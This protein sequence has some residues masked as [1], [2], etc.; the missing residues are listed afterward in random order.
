MEDN[1]LLD[2]HPL[3]EADDADDLDLLDA[4]TA[5]HARRNADRVLPSPQPM[6]RTLFE[7]SIDMDDLVLKDFGQRV[8]GPLSDYFGTVSAKGGAFFR[9]KAAE[10][11]PNTERYQRDQTLRGHLINGML[12]ARRTP[13]FQSTI[14]TCSPI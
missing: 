3:D 9:K 13:S 6:F 10:N 1:S 8:I 4:I 12:P 2:N 7:Q 14:A 11:A 5:Q